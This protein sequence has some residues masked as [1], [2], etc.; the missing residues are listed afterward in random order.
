MG[1]MAT[2]LVRDLS[3][4][5]N[6]PLPVI[7]VNA[8]PAYQHG[9]LSALRARGCEPAEP[10]DSPRWAREQERCAV[11]FV[12]DGDGESSETEQL[13]SYADL[14]NAHVV[15]LLRRPTAGI[16]AEV[17]Q[18]GVDGIAAWDSTTEQLVATITAAASGFVMLP[19]RI[20]RQ[21]ARAERPAPDA[22]GQLP[23]EQRG[24][25]RQLAGGC[26]VT[27]LAKR[28]GYSERAMHRLLRNLYRSLGVDNRSHA[29]V[30]ASRAG[31][32]DAGEE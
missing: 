10:R 18:A 28:A 20:A 12:I 16:T 2:D 21:L 27:Q 23:E 9:L 30:L 24:W 17:I 6:G 5:A 15:A 31:L 29:L 19:A 7:I 22:L 11:L 1:G 14:P 4:T 13:R 32:L 3:I 8:P 25:L 26:T